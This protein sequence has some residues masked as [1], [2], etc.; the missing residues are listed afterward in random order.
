[1][2]GSWDGVARDR[3]ADPAAPF[4]ALVF[5]VVATATGRLTFVRVYSGTVHKGDSVLDAGSGRTERIARILRVQADRHTELDA[6]DGRRHR[7][8]GRPEGR[9]GRRDPLRAG[10]PA[11]PRTARGR[12]AGGLRGGRGT[13]G[14]DTERLA[15]ALAQLVEEDPSLT[16]RN[17]AQTGQTVLSGMGEL[18]LEVAVEKIRRSRELDIG[19]GRPQVAYRETVA[20]G[21]SGLV[22]RHVKQD[23]GAG[24]FAHVVLDVEPLA[25]GRTGLRVPRRPSSAAGCRGS[26]SGPW[27]RAAGMRCPKARSAA[28]PSPGSGHP[29][30][31]RTHPKDSSEMAF[32]SPAGSASGRRCA[33]A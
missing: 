3:P 18:H 25:T 5:K 10:G 23:G 7:R 30:R 2:R 1:M 6:G 20:S 26:T 32:R 4:T 8:R 22:Y 28:T 13:Q 33:P 14:T 24:Q 15:T 31:R 11:A 27:K 21:V 29:H 19:V 12:R 16:V 17:D 9:P